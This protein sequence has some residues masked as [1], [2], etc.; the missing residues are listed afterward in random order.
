M[1]LDA[2]AAAELPVCDVLRHHHCKHVLMLR[3]VTLP[4]RVL[5]RTP[6][7]TG[8]PPPTECPIGSH[9]D[10]D[11]ASSILPHSCV[12]LLLLLLLLLGASTTW[13]PGLQMQV[14]LQLAPPPQTGC[15]LVCS[16]FSCVTPLAWPGNVSCSGAA[17]C[18]PSFSQHMCPTE[19]QHASTAL[20]VTGTCQLRGIV[21]Q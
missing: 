19:C 11:A 7:L 6:A 9:G 1:A 4:T 16:C 10:G 14:G 5:Q 2:E 21:A 12:V 18:P 20:H 13:E 15:T 8:I 17:P 3:A